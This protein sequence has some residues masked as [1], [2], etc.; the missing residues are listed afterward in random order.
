M[1]KQ[2][3]DVIAYQD[4]VR[5]F[6]GGQVLEALA[7]FKFAAETG[8][9]RPMEHFALAS[10]YAQVGQLDE[11]ASE[12]RMFLDTGGGQPAQEE[13]ARA[14][15][16]SIGRKLAEAEA[17]RIAAAKAEQEQRL[18]RVRK[19]FD[20]A[21]S[22]YR[23][24]GYQSALERLEELL[25]SWGRTA[26]VLN[27]VGL[28]HL[29]LHDYASALA[30]LDEGHRSNPENGDILLNLARAHFEGGCRPARAALENLVKLHPEHA[31]AWYNLGVLKLANSDFK[32]AKKAWARVLDMNPDDDDARA[33]LEMLERRE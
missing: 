24:G 20:D 14:A 19:S 2:P 7:K 9:D 30:V 13:A 17:E 11:A 27:L 8:V 32:G 29:H 18:R 28:C 23:A 21:V 33:N 25:E 22:Y 10:A 15:L 3:D 5:L 6:R 4:G 16:E 26:E 1:T 12:Y 31:G